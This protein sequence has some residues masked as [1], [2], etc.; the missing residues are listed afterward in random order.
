MPSRRLPGGRRQPR[1]C[2]ERARKS[3][4]ESTVD[5]SNPMNE[6]MCFVCVSSSVVD[7]KTRGQLGQ[8]PAVFAVLSCVRVCV[9][10]RLFASPFMAA[11]VDYDDVFVFFF[12]DNN[13]VFHCRGKKKLIQNGM[14]LFLHRTLSVVLHAVNRISFFLFFSFPVAC[15]SFGFVLRQ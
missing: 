14:I 2:R 8:A 15:L 4:E 7:T 13:I 11:F 12:L 3:G 10:P 5:D 6:C 9:T 1:N